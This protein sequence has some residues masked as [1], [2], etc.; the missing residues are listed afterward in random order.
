MTIGE[1]QQKIGQGL[2]Q[3]VDNDI[4]IKLVFSGLSQY[5]LRRGFFLVTDLRYKNEANYL[6]RLD[7][8]VVLLRINPSYEGYEQNK[9]G[10][11]TTHSSEID[12][13]DYTG[14]DYVIENN[15]SISDLENKV[16][17][18]CNS[19]EKTAPK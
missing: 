15:G 5:D 7:T 17:E 18:F 2:R 14:W 6:K 16:I 8:D 10:R 9:S 19:L 12:L 4:W 1:M 13:D 11:D 3:V